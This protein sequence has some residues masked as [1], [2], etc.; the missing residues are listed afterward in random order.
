M[1]AR[2]SIVQ[3]ILR[4]R[5]DLLRRI[6]V[7]VEERRGITL[8]Y[9]CPHCHQFPL[10]DYIWW[11]FFRDTERSNATG[12]VW[13][14]EASTNGRPQIESWS[15]KAQVFRAH[16]APQGVSNNLISALRPLANHRKMVT[17]QSAWWNRAFQKNLRR[18]A[19]S[20]PMTA[21]VAARKGREKGRRRETGVIC[22]SPSAVNIPFILGRTC[23]TTLI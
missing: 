6:I 17:A 21:K 4:T 22:P 13:R 2:Q 11:F 23:V 16:A 18:A 15:N 5:T 12:G 9:V 3:E 7:P 20:I 8:P 19:E 14:A 10:E 1:R